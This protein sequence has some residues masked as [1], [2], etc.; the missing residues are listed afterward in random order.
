M[1]LI[2]N[3]CTVLFMQCGFA[4]LEA[5]AVRAKNVTN[6][7]MKNFLDACKSIYWVPVGPGSGG[8]RIL[9]FWGTWI[10]LFLVIGVI[11][12]WICGFAFAFGK[13]KYAEIGVDGETIYKYSS[14]N[15]FIGKC[16]WTSCSVTKTCG[17]YVTYIMS[18]TSKEKDFWVNDH[19]TRL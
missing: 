6:I 18:I 2:I 19:F 8:P 12:Y 7:L 14:A 11:I 3:G 17:F 9:D 5:G 15:S 16:S 10:I 1:F 4:L 13:N